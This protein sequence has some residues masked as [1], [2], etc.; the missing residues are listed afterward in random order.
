MIP[1]TIRLV[2][3]TVISIYEEV[4]SNKVASIT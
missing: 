1:A 4:R 2:K 3:Q